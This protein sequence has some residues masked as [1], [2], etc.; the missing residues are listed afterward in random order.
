MRKEHRTLPSVGLLA[1][2]VIASLAACSDTSRPPGAQP[3]GVPKMSSAKAGDSHGGSLYISSAHP[4]PNGGVIVFSGNPLKYT[5]TISNGIGGPQGLA[6]NSIGQLY[7]ANFTAS[8]V[9]IY[10]K[11]GTSP[12]RTLSK[13]LNLPWQIAVSSKGDVYVDAKKHVNIYINSRQNKFKRIKLVPTGIA[14]DSSDNA[15]VAADGIISV[16]PP[17]TTQPTRTITEGLSNPGPLAIDNAGNLYVANLNPSPC[18][19]VTVYD[20]ATGVLENT[21]TDGVCA[22]VSFAFDSL[23]DVYVGNYYD[24]GT[25]SVTMYAGGTGALMETITKGIIE[26]LALAVDSSDDLYVANTV[27]N[28]NVVV[29]SPNQTSPSTTL[30]KNL[31]YPADLVWIQ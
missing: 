4:A 22:P 3:F 26:P 30:T 31:F 15:Y 8:T 17:G 21:L 23:N 19:N 14:I 6:L 12:V 13:A 25:P 1:C 9:T 27:E 28:G 18:G 16:F 7:V 10:N 5:R 24:R 29:Y 20:A 2:L 11:N